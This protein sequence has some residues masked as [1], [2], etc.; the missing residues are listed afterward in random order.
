MLGVRLGTMRAK[1]IYNL[2]NMKLTEKHRQDVDD[3]IWN[4]I[5]YSWQEARITHDFR[6]KEEAD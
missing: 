2:Q 3:L 4:F 6:I 1:I 5:W